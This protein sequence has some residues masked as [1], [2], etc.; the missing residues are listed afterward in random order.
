MAERVVITG[1]GV[2]SSLGFGL[3]EFWS[4][5]TSGTSG[6]SEVTSFKAT[7]LERHRGG[8]I[9]DF[10]PSRLFPLAA[11][12][13]L[14]RTHQFALVAAYQ[15][16]QDSG[17]SKTKNVGMVFGSI[18]AGSE[19]IDGCCKDINQYP[20]YMAASNICTL[21]GLSA[22]AFTLSGACA[23]GNYAIS[24]AYERI[25]EGREAVI[26]AGSA[27]YFSPGTFIGLYRVFSLAPLCCQPFDKNRRGL[28]PAEGAG[29]LVL[30][31]LSSAKKRKAHIY[32]E[33]LGYGLSADAHHALIP[34]GDGVFHCMKNAL[35][36][37]KLALSDIDY[38]NAHG[39]GT[40]PNDRTECAAIKKL[41]G[42]KRSRKIPV[43]SIKS[44]LGH[45]MA[46]ASAI[47]AIACC[48]TLKTGVIAPTINYETPDPECD[49]DC[50]PNKARRQKVR[51]VLNNAFGFGGMNCSV[52]LA[53]NAS[54]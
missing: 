31:S 34:S 40:V 27:D 21:L 42:Q 39:T 43:S 10:D 25:K 6:I 50:V 7:H 30:E 53:R 9:K 51:V 24:L 35:D 1:L 4:G 8:E 20:V 47:E 41:F 52:A 32:A 48:L 29:M 17:V 23:A 44:V 54:L 22:S 38:I 12:H 37:T 19:F 33:V 26:L 11:I 46:A 16:L 5:L 13:K 18:V 2:V 15:A 49:I 3:D 45:T 14:P 28:I 36:Q